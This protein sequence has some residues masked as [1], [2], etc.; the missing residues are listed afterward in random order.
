[1]KWNKGMP[2]KTDAEY[3]AD[4]KANCIITESGCWEWQGW[5][6]R[7]KG[8]KNAERGY[9]GGSYRGKRARLHRLVLSWKVGRP[10]KTEEFTCHSCDKPNCINPDHLSIG[11]PKSNMQEA[12]AK[13]RWP[14]QRKEF[15]KNG[16]PRT[17]ENLRFE[18]P[19]SWDCKMC[20]TVKNRKKAG[21]PKELWNADIRVPPGYM[22]CRETW[23]VVPFIGKRN[24]PTKRDG[25]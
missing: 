24:T 11:T 8:M 6:T 2:H 9:P 4:W 18:P 23:K 17:P 25:E 1:M 7:S 22:M 14:R 20:G 12:G 19:N 21:W 16:H 3:L 13:R 5:Q 15:C 10:L